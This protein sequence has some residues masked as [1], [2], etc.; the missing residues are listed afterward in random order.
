[1]LAKADS[2]EDGARKSWRERERLVVTKVLRREWY[3]VW[4]EFKEGA[5]KDLYLRVEPW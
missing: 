5:R 3:V 4:K 2:G 1:M